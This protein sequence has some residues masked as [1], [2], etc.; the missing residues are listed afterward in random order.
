VA[1]GE[2][3]AVTLANWHRFANAIALR[4]RRLYLEY[5]EQP[6]MIRKLRGRRITKVLF[7]CYGN[8]CRSPLAAAVAGKRFPKA[9]F[10]SA[11]FCSTTGRQSP[12]FLLT[13]ADS[14]GV[15]LTQ[16][17]SK[18]VDAK[19]L[20]EAELVVIMDVRNHELL[21]KQFPHALQKTLLLGM[22]LP[23][24]QLEI[25]DPYDDPALMQ[26]IASKMNCAIEQMRNFL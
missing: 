2:L 25:S 6:R 3:T 20:D 26:T 15:N 10:S 11:G 17:R 12:D 22:L 16:H 7:L 13:A 21:K 4:S 14:L 1:L 18:C 9:R 8:I 19:M 5:I 23:E 24:P